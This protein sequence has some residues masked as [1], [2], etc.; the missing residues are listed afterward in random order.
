MV[1]GRIKELENWP[2]EEKS[3]K[4]DLSRRIL[5]FL[6][7]HGAKPEGEIAFKL[8]EREREVHNQLLKLQSGGYVGVSFQS[9]LSTTWHITEGRRKPLRPSTRKLAS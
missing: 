9:F 6:K 5:E 1:N 4:K 8:N 2:E 7:E 3:R